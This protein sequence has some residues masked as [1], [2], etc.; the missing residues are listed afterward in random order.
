MRMDGCSKEQEA[1]REFF[2]KPLRRMHQV[3]VRS[4]D[5]CACQEV[6]GDRSVQVSARGALRV[7]L[8]SEARWLPADA[9]V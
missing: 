1:H 9:V 3:T 2:A 8:Y 7:K 6:A 5:L 4:M